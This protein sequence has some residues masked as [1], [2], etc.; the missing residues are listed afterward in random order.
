M[1]RAWDASPDGPRGKRVPPLGPLAPAVSLAAKRLGAMTVSA[2]PVP[3]RWRLNRL[4][5]FLQPPPPTR[6]P[7]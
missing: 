1:S 4:V 3:S 7:C 2:E 6:S 5:A